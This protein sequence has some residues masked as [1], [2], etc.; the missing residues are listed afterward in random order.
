MIYIVFGFMLIALTI[1]VVLATFL[2]IDVIKFYSKYRKHSKQR[3]QE[4]QTQLSKSE[5]LSNDFDESVYPRRFLGASRRFVV[6][7]MF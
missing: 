7:R 6:F 2:L 1:Q 4:F 5:Q 3:L